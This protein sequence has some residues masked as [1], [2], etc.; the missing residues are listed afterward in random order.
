MDYG[1]LDMEGI[2][3][4]GDRGQGLGDRGRRREEQRET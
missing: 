2:K 3:G 1:S 4:V